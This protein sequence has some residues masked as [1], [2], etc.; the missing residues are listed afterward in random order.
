MNSHPFLASF[1]VG[2]PAQ[3]LEPPSSDMRCNIGLRLARLWIGIRHPLSPAA[4]EAGKSVVAIITAQRPA[5]RLKVDELRML[6]L[7]LRS[8][9]ESKLSIHHPA[10]PAD[11][12]AGVEKA[13]YLGHGFHSEI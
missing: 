10:K 5:N 4:A 6:G 9:L 1:L 11:L 2:K 7:E 3:A 8:P 12:A 13:W